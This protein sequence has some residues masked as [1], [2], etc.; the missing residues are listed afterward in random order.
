M[1]GTGILE[2]LVK[3]HTVL[4]E[5]A[6]KLPRLGLVGAERKNADKRRLPEPELVEIT[7][8]SK[9]AH[10][11]CVDIGGKLHQLLAPM[12]YWRG[13]KLTH[14]LVRLGV[15]PLDVII[16]SASFDGGEVSWEFRDAVEWLFWTARD[17]AALEAEV[18]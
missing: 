1:S 7:S 2:A 18:A 5:A 4:S 10:V 11:L 13:Q 8:K 9:D 15:H 16:C 12:P 6:R 3:R 17:Q 14:E